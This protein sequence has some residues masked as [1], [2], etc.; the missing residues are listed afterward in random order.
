MFGKLNATSFG[1]AQVLIKEFRYW[2]KRVPLWDLQKI[3]YRQLDP[4]SVSGLVSYVRLI[5]GLDNFLLDLV[6]LNP[7]VQLANGSAQKNSMNNSFAAVSMV[8][9]FTENNQT[10][11]DK[12]AQMGHLFQ[13]RQFHTICPLQT[14]YFE[15][16]KVCV[17]EPVNEAILAVFPFLGS[18]GRLAWLF[19]L[20][21]SAVLNET[22]L[23]QLQIKWKSEDYFLD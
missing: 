9:D 5:G 2:N 13:R 17:G 7:L 15:M 23:W 16:Q 3:R 21:H 11:I 12:M 14:Y 18:N 8:A 1:A 6:S 22:L 20:E 4:T 19:T 10:M